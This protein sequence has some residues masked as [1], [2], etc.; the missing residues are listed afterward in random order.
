M[1]HPPRVYTYTRER[2]KI[3]FD[4]DDDGAATGL[5]ERMPKSELEKMIERGVKA[6]K[7]GCGT[8]ALIERGFKSHHIARVLREAGMGKK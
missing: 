1:C 3:V 7:S 5:R 6:L 2:E 8:D 4:N